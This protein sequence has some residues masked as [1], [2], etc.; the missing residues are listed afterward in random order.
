MAF[1]CS[2]KTQKKG[3]KREKREE[4]SYLRDIPENDE[5][6]ES[7]LGNSMM[8]NKRKSASEIKSFDSTSP[9]KWTNKALKYS[10]RNTK[11]NRLVHKNSKGSPSDFMKIRSNNLS[12][13]SLGSNSKA[14]EPQESSLSRNS[15]P[16]KI[17]NSLKKL[18]RRAENLS[19]KGLGSKR[20][21]DRSKDSI[22][23]LPDISVFAKSIVETERKWENTETTSILA[24]DEKKVE[25][26]SNIENLTRYSVL[27]KHLRNKERRHYSVKKRTTKPVFLK[28]EQTTD[29]EETSSFW[30]LLEDP[31]KIE[32]IIG[33]LTD[34]KDDIIRRD[35]EKIKNQVTKNSVIGKIQDFSDKCMK[36][37]KKQQEIIKK[38]SKLSMP[39]LPRDNSN[40]KLS[41]ESRTKSVNSSREGSFYSNV[42]Q[43]N[44]TSLKVDENLYKELVKKLKVIISSKDK[45][46]ESNNKSIDTLKD[47]IKMLEQ[48]LSELKKQSSIVINTDITKPTIEED[49]YNGSIYSSETEDVYCMKNLSMSNYQPR[50]SK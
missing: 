17:P 48:E 35:L 4:R 36:V 12:I 46:L 40:I 49:D 5:E 6:L 43:S 45:E 41:N 31:T 32:K 29:T 16:T 20:F 37:I 21:L 50:I 7:P 23:E 13:I 10:Y 44:P 9:T 11:L 18:S 3:G 27:S 19:Q 33:I 1:H 22:P 42:R 2:V 25:D 30:S 8:I 14:E 38:L 24:N 26:Y 34:L 28:K 39:V 15:S 47:R